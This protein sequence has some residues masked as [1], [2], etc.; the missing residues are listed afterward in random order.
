MKK[1]GLK[2]TRFPS[3]LGLTV[4][5]VW[6]GSVLLSPSHAESSVSN[7]DGTLATSASIIFK[8]IIPERLEVRMPLGFSGD[9]EDDIAADYVVNTR[10]LSVTRNGVLADSDAR[11]YSYVS[12]QNVHQLTLSPPSED[13]QNVSSVASPYTIGSP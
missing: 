7:G 6:G 12:G 11:V 1:L 13:E 5:V 8:I 4:T 10:S 3:I 9:T 2:K